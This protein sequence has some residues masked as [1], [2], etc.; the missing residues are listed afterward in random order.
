MPARTVASGPGPGPA[1]QTDASHEL[2]VLLRSRIPLI[3]LETQ[4]EARAL[5]L[6]ASLAVRLARSGHVP[7]FQWTVTDGLRRLDLELG[8]PQRHDAEPLDVLKYIRATQIAGV[9]V[10]VDFHPFMSEPRHVRMLKDICLEYDKAART[11]VLLSHE[12][13]LPRELEPFSARFELALPGREERRAL[14]EDIA[15]EWVAANPGSRVQA[16]RQALELLV[17][18]MA[19]LTTGDTLRLARKA[20]FD[21]GALSSTDLPALME[22]KYQLLN[23]AGVISYEHDTVRFADVGGLENLKQWLR[24]RKPAFEAK[25]QALDP[26]KG[27]LLLGVQ[28]CGKSLAARAAAGIFQVPLLRLDFSAIHSKWHGESERNLR[29]T[30]KTAELMAPCVVWIDEV[31]KGVATGEGDSGT[32]RRA[33]GTLLTWLAEKKSRVFVVATAND[34]SALPPEL[35]RKGRFDETFFVDLPKEAIRAQ[36]LEIHARKR[37]ATLTAPEVAQLAA[38]SDGFS[39]AELEQVIVSALYSAYAAQEP[40]T[41]ALVL[42]EIKATRPLSLIMAERIHDLREWASERTVPA[43]A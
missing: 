14:V 10:L 31:E 20:I 27:L 26:P 8:A 9:Y 38:G 6:L 34:I 18:N 35:I 19:G 43:D 5:A 2:A 32:S 16:D 22:A 21:D 39:G 25:A 30:L 36:I 13:T 12:F 3:V 40:L 7:M 17:E 37:G 33:L 24:H 42:K 23:R 15:T 41:A 4:E 1:P 11:V 28:G 29:D